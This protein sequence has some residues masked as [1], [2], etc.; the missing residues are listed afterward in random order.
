[1]LA[2]G[3]F[4]DMKALFEFYHRVLEVSKARTTA[5]F[6]I[7]GGTFFPET[8]QQTGLYLSGEMGWQCQ[9][10]RDKRNIS[11]GVRVPGN[12]YIRYHR[13]GGLELSLLA[14]DWLEHSGDVS[15]FQQTLL[16]QIV[17]YVVSRRR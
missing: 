2:D 5:W 15:Y 11:S 10:T 13:E 1:M 9:T 7:E 16:P 14:L 8:M 17:L 6:G 3:R 4:E 12:P